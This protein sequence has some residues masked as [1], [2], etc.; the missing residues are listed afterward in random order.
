MAF[1]SIQVFPCVSHVFSHVFLLTDV[2]F[3]QGYEADFR[4]GLVHVRNNAEAPQS[5]EGKSR[6]DIMALQQLHSISH[7]I[8]M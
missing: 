2:L 6:A 3:D 4:Y 7:P 1:F 5:W 8:A